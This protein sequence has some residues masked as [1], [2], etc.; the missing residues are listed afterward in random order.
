MCTVV[1]VV[2]TFDGDIEERGWQLI[3]DIESAIDEPHLDVMR[4]NMRRLR[5]QFESENQPELAEAA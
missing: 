4:D 5:E 1:E 2:R 3:K